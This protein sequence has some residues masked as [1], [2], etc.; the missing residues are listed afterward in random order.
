MSCDEPNPPGESEC[1]ALHVTAESSGP[2]LPMTIKKLLKRMLR[3]YGLRCV[4]ITD[5]TDPRKRKK[6]DGR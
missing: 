2:E 4:N 5:G 6:G 3:A 1:W